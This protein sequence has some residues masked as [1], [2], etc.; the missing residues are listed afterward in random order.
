MSSFKQRMIRAFDAAA[1]YD[2]VATIQQQ[3]AAALARRIV[4]LPLPPQARILEVGCG[5]G[6]VAAALPSLPQGAD[7]LMTDVS[8]AMVRRARQR[9]QGQIGYRFAVLDAEHPGFDAPEQPFDLICSSLA[10]QW[11]EDLPRA[12]GQ[13]F[14]LVNPGGHLLI[15]T[16]A[17]GTFAEW[18]AAHDV[19]GLTA[20]TP[21]Y[22]DRAALEGLLLD[23]Q[24]ASVEL[25]TFTSSYPSGR[26]FLRALRTIGAATPR[27][28]H[29]P[30]SPRTMQKVLKAFESGGSSI[31]WEVAFCS[32][33]RPNELA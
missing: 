20:G 10:A 13:L 8:P 15:S 24:P 7:W 30:L 11:F 3:V 22:P 2:Q 18:R 4:A 33:Q 1:G 6:F 17:A 9:F 29:R 16:L 23:G 25:E 14:R 21:D 28:G 5:T 32:F 12:L 19:L 31:S 27:P 26:D